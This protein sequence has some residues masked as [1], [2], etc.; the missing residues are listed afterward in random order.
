MK[1]ILLLLTIVLLSGNAMAS[2]SNN[3]DEVEVLPNEL[4]VG[5]GICQWHQW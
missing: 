2:Q 1:K 3:N 4:S 5:I